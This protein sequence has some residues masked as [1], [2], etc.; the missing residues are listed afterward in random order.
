[1]EKT[2]SDLEIQKCRVKVLENI[3]NEHEVPLPK[4]EEI[5]LLTAR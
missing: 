2:E 4:D 3:M 1:L 5:A